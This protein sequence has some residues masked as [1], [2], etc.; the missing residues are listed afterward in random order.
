MAECVDFELARVWPRIRTMDVAVVPFVASDHLRETVAVL[1]RVR[2]A[3]PNYPPPTDAEDSPTSLSRWLLDEGGSY[4][5]RW[6]ALVGDR[7]VGHVS[8]S[9]PHDYILK[10]LRS[11]EY[12]LTKIDQ[13][14]EV[15]K[16][17][18][19]PTVQR[20]GVGSRLFFQACQF[21][22]QERRTPVLAVVDTSV[23]ARHFYRHSG[24][25]DLGVFEG[26]HGTNH[27][28]GPTAVNLPRHVKVE[29]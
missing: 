2:A 16:F 29:Q 4:L 15:T 12:Q 25:E 21:A 19:D 11:I 18:V 8:V 17:F 28:F 10:F 7:V 26:F 22:S 6:A 1:H 14:C 3:D 13:L 23:D 27:V 20:L 5:S 9:L 24:M